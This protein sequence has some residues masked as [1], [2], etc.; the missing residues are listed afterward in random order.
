MS[1]DLLHWE[2][3]EDALHPDSLGTMFSGS[4]VIDRR[5]S[6][7]FGDDYPDLDPPVTK[8][9]TDVHARS[10]DICFQLPRQRYRQLNCNIVA[11]GWL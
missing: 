4:A 7:G 9:G 5:N 11:F 2:Q 1:D 10:E 3:L 6:A 8:C